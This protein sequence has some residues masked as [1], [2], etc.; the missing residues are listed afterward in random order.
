M[1]TSNKVA[2]SIL[3][4]SIKVSI[5]LLS[6]SGQDSYQDKKK[7]GSTMNI[8]LRSMLSAGIKIALQK[9]LFLFYHNLSQN[10][11]YSWTI[12]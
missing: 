7:Q 9:I 12:H 10:Q 2:Y 5:T 8:G 11:D 3:A 6:R 1:S 4:C